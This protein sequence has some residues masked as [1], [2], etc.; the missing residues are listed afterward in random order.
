MPD[1]IT[2]PYERER[3]GFA[4]RTWIER[5]TL[6][7]PRGAAILDLGCGGGEPIARYLVDHGFTIT[8]VDNAATMIDLARTRFPRQRWLQA[9]MRKLVL[10]DRFEGAVAW[11][12]LF[13]LPRDDQ[14]AM[15]VRIASWL[16]PGGRLLFNTGPAQ[17][18]AAGTTRGDPP[19]HASLDPA[20][21]RAAFTR[22][23]LVE[24]AHVAEDPA[25]GGQTVW[26]AR[27]P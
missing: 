19:W 5:L 13:H 12:S 22:A 7:L 27:K 23:G 21:C 9:D 17:G 14:D 11:N 26:L 25:C 10:D 2:D 16:K 4:E 24:M 20:A 3:S 1:R 15:I 6:P 8:G 18:E